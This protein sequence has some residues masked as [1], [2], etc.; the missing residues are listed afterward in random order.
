MK[1]YTYHDVN[2]RGTIT[3]VTYRALN[4]AGEER[5]KY[6]N[7]YLPYGY[8]PQDKSKQYNVLYLMHGGGG[9]PDAWLDCCKIKNMLDYC[10][11]EKVALPFLVVFPTYYK[12]QVNRIGPPDEKFER[13]SLQFFQDELGAQLLPAVES[14]F[15]TYAQDVTPQS[16][17][18]SRAH[19]AF[20]GFSMGGATTWF[21]LLENAK[22]FATFLPLSGDCWVCRARGGA[23]C[24]E[25][26]V[27]AMVEALKNEGLTAEDYRILSATGTED[28]AYK[29][30]MPQFE[31]MK[32]YPAFFHYST[33]CRQGNFHYFIAD[34]Y[35]HS[36][37]C[38]Y[39]YIY[40]YLPVIFI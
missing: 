28:P 13:E 8:N 5:E 22:Y 17:Q 32:K 11:A 37:E 6:A 2:F 38:V 25:Q 27:S 3:Q 14:R 39:Q 7:V 9:N 18:Q 34:G 15:T 19:R 10:F 16:L 33:D 40:N 35:V 36:Y 30:L 12:E 20:G 21:A 1:E 31:E 29:N 23:L 26:T 24:P 4:K